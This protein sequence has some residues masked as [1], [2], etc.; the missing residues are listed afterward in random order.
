MPAK[1][2][3]ILIVNSDRPTSAVL[4]EE[5]RGLEYKVVTASS[6]EELDRIIDSGARF[7]L[8]VIDLSG[9]DDEIWERCDRIRAMKT[10]CIAIA[11]HRSVSTLRETLAH[12]ADALLVAPVPVKEIIEHIRTTLGG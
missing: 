5:L 8:S 11:P 12:G 6:L 3:P 2:L 7:L 4:A 1:E 10:P 9:F